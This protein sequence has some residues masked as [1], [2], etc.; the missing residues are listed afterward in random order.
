MS[1]CMHHCMYAFKD[2]LMDGKLDEGFRFAYND[3]NI[4]I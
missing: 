2:K 4:Y 1:V 3:T